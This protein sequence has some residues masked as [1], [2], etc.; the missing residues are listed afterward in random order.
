MSIGIPGKITWLGHAA[1]QVTTSAGR[2]VLIDPWLIG[3]PACP[4][5][6]RRPAHCDAIL[7]THA[8]SDHVGDTVEI[9]KRTGAEVVA[10]V[11]LAQ[12]LSQKGVTRAIGMNKGGTVSVAGL[13]VTMVQAYHSSSIHDGSQTLYG[14]EAAGLVVTMDGGFNFYHAGDTNVF[15]DMSLIA[16]LY[17]PTLGMLPI[18]GHYTMSPKE[19][20]LAV[21]LLRLKHVIPMHH[22][23]FP[24]LT[25]A[26]AQLVANLDNDSSITVHALKPGDTLE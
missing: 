25:G 13:D 26:P 7:L 3:N 11:E 22:G 17:S 21:R 15:G 12:W 5:H 24:V 4:E 19:A 6:L 16:E 9:A 2:V 1:F 8:H 18:G 20:A 23:T 10:M 14:G